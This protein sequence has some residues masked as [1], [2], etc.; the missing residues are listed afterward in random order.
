MNRFSSFPVA[1]SAGETPR[2]DEMT[3]HSSRFSPVEN[4]FPCLCMCIH[5]SY[6]LLC[7]FLFFFFLFHF[8]YRDNERVQLHRTVI[9]RFKIKMSLNEQ[10][11]SLRKEITCSTVCTSVR[12]YSKRS[13]QAMLPH[14]ETEGQQKKKKKKNNL[15][16]VET[17]VT[18]L[19]NLQ[20]LWGIVKKLQARPISRRINEMILIVTV[21]STRM[22][23]D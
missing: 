13:R 20:S 17:Q 2:A 9:G 18:S 15:A 19:T 1:T 5:E 7:S 21:L 8:S 10:G 11:L 22:C 16:L 6:K 4:V 14:D 3:K 12:K 23:R